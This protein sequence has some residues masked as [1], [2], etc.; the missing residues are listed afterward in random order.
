MSE[1]KLF[2]VVVKEMST[3]KIVSTIGT[4]LTED[5]AE[6]RVETGLMRINTEAYFVDTVPAGT[7]PPPRGKTE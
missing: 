5:K 2:D 4:N 1:P 3:G 6:R 7:A